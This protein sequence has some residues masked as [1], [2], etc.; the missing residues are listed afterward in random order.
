M[1]DTSN[2]KFDILE[3]A[4]VLCCKVFTLASVLPIQERNGLYKNLRLSS[5][6]LPIKIAE[7]NESDK[8]NDCLA[9]LQEAKTLLSLIEVEVA[10]AFQ[11]KYIE[12]STLDAIIQEIQ[13]LKEYLSQ[14]INNLKIISSALNH[15]FAYYPAINSN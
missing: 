14:M 5:E 10:I 12:F 9:K 13:S 2:S 7:G 3:K 15:S 1:E 11:L 6:L 8:C 4:T